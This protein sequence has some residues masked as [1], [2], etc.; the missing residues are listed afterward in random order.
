M[1]AQREHELIL[2]WPRYRKTGVQRR[3]TLSSVPD[4]IDS[5]H[6][7][8]LDE[9][10]A[11]RCRVDGEIED[12]DIRISRRLEQRM[13]CD[14]EVGFRQVFKAELDILQAIDKPRGQQERRHA[15]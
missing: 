10:L 4:G 8:E 12:E 5:V 14:C 7:R 6:Y 15:V 9:L 3:V 13:E 2:G 1:R 11:K